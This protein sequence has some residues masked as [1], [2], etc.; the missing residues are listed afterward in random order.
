MFN[1][2]INLKKK[3]VLIFILSHHLVFLLA[4]LLNQRWYQ[5]RVLTTFKNDLHCRAKATHFAQSHHLFTWRVKEIGAYKLK[6]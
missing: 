4:Q 1:K 5:H 3:P 2:Y 6:V